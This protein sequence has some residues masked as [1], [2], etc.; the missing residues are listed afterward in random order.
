MTT[1]CA[2]CLPDRPISY[3]PPAWGVFF[4]AGQYAKINTFSMRVYKYGFS[5]NVITT[6][7]LLLSIQVTTLCRRRLGVNKIVCCFPSLFIYC[8]RSTLVVNND[9]YKICHNRPNTGH[10]GTGRQYEVYCRL[11]KRCSV[12]LST[13]F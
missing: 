1:C 6:E 4:A 7:E 13:F 5:T 11:Y 8:V 2:Y 9:E 10:M 3:A 12:L